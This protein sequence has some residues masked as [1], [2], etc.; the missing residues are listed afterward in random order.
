MRKTRKKKPHWMKKFLLAAYVLAILWTTVAYAL[1]DRAADLPK[2]SAQTISKEVATQLKRVNVQSY[3]HSAAKDAGVNPT[4][5]EWIVAHESSH[6]PGVTGDGGASRGLWQI[7][8]DWHPE[9]SD[10]CAY[11]VKCSTDWSLGRIRSGYSYEWS[12]WKYCR[13][14]FDDCPF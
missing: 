13:E 3:V 10:S 7:N 14:K 11:D 5:A 6:R 2:L 9:V 1:T 12:T 8:K 4:V